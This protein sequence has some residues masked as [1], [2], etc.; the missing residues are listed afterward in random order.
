MHGLGRCNRMFGSDHQPHHALGRLRY[1][2]LGWVG[3]H[4]TVIVKPT[5]SPTQ[6]QPN[7]RKIKLLGH[8]FP[9]QLI[10]RGFG[11]VLC[12]KQNT[13]NLTQPSSAQTPDSWKLRKDFANACH[14]VD[15]R[16]LCM[17]MY[18]STWYRYSAPMNMICT[19]CW[20]CAPSYRNSTHKRKRVLRPGRSVGKD[21]RLSLRILEAATFSF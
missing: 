5:N 10:F 6:G 9:Q 2:K 12:R 17:R 13:R 11:L 18:F 7:P 4:V 14:F 16:T 19:C 20:K 8:F 21:F 1:T 15:R 3:K